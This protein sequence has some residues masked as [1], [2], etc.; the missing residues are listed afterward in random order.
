[1]CARVV[2]WSVL[3]LLL[4]AGAGLVWLWKSR[5][6]QKPAPAAVATANPSGSSVMKS[7]PGT[8]VTNGAGGA[9]PAR[10]NWF[11]YRL[12]NTPQSIGELMRDPQAILLENALIDTRRPVNFSIPPHLRASG[13]PGAYIVQSRGPITAAFR[14]TLA[15]AGAEIVSYIPNNAYLVRVSAAGAGALAGA[16]GVQ[17]VIPYEPYFKLEPALLGLA[18]Q[19]K[20]LPPGT[21]LEVGLFASDATATEQRLA[22]LGAKFLGAPGQSPFGPVV[23]VLAPENWTALAQVPGVQ[24]VEVSHQKI[25]ANDLSR[26]T[27][28]VAADTQTPTNYLNL[29]GKNVLVAVDDTG[30]DATHPDLAGRVLGLNASDLV[31]T[32]GHGTHVAGTI[33]GDGTKSTTVTNAEGSIMPATNG[34]F[35]GMAPKAMLFSVNRNNPDAVLQ[36]LAA[37]TNALIS[38]NS[39]DYGGD[40]D[41]DLAAASYDWATRDA[42]PLVTGAQ[43]VLFVF[44]AGDSG[45]GSDDGTGG[46][47]DTILSP[48]T[49][50]NV[51]TVGALEQL[52]NITNLVTDANS[53]QSAFW[54]PRTDSSTQVAGYSSRG[55]VGVGVEGPFGRFKPDVVAPGTFVISTRSSQW[56]T[57]AYYNPTNVSVT[58][59]T[60]Q[61]VFSNAPA[62]YT[63]SVPPNA[64]GVVI[65]I[66]SNQFSNPFP[67]NL[68]IYVAQNGVPGPGNYDFFTTKDGVSI[69]PDGP[70]NYLQQVQNNGFSFAVYDNLTGPVNYD[71][72]VAILTTNN[73]GNLY[74]VL[75]GMNDA[76]GGYYRYESGT[77][78]A[79]ADVSGVLALIADYFTNQLHEIPSPALLK[80]LLINGARTLSGYSLAFTNGINYQGWGLIN[81]PDSLPLT[82]T[83]LAT[84]P[85]GQ[86]PMPIF[87]VDQS[88][89]NAL[90]TGDRHTYTVTLSTNDFAQ[91]LPLK[92][93]L[94]WSDPPGNPAA[95]IK[96]VNSLELI[97]TNLDTGDVYF[98]NDIPP[99]ASYSQPGDTNAPNFDLV[100]NV[101]SVLLPPP[102]ADRYSVTVLGRQVNV[103]AV[104]E[105]TNNV[106]QDYALVVTVGE[107]EVPTAIAS[108][109]D[110]GVVSNPTADQDVTGVTSTNMPLFNQFAGANTPLLGTNTL[111]LGNNTVWGPNGQVTIGMT[112]QWHFYI[113]TNNAVDQN[114]LTAD[115]TN[116][117]FITFD[118]STLS[119][120]RTG[121]FADSTADATRPEADIDLYVSRDPNL[122]NL[123]PTVISNCLAGVG[124]NRASLGRGGTEFVFYTNSAPGEV[125]YVGVKSED[126]EASEY[127]FMPIFTATPFSQLNQNGDLIVNGLLLPVNIPD[128]D[129]A[130]PGV[131]NVFALA[132]PLI[133]GMTVAKV[134]VTNLNEH[135]NFGDLF[136]ALS[137]GGRSVVLNNHAGYGNTFGTLPRIYDDSLDPVP[138][139]QPSDGPGSLT[140]FRGLSA[141]GPWILTEIDSSLTQTGRVS[142]F[143]LLIQPHRNLKNGII[144]SIPPQGW[145]IDF[146]DVTPGYTNLTFYATNLPPTIGPPPLQMFERLG[147]EPTLTNFDQEADLTNSPPGQPP[148]PNGTDPG[149]LISVG[150]PLDAGRYFVG[151]YNPSTVT[152]NVFLQATLGQG[153]LA[154][155]TFNYS[156]NPATAL[157]DD[158]VSSSSIF[159]PATNPIVSVNVGLIVQTPR[160]SD[161]TFTLISPTGQRILLM[162]NRGGTDT[163][164]VGHL[165]VF[166]NF[167]GPLVSGGLATTNISIGPVPNVGTL[168]INY[169]FF[170][171]PD[172]LAVYYDG[173][174]IFSTTN[175]NPPTGLISG[176]GQF[177]IPY[178]PGLSSNLVVVMNPGGNPGTTNDAWTFTPMVVAEDYNYL[179]FTDDTNLAQ[180]PIKFAIPPFDMSATGTN[181]VFSDFESATNGDYLA[182][183]NIYDPFG[184]WTMVTNRL[185]GTNQVFW[186][187]NLV[188]VAGDPA[189]AQNGSNYLA[190]GLGS[191]RRDVPLTVGRK[192]QIAFG[193]RGPGISAWW[194]GEGNASDS[195]DPEV[196]GNNGRLIGRFQFPAGEVGQAFELADQGGQFDFAGTNNYVQIPQSPSLDVGQG[197]GFTVEGWI[198]PTNVT[199]PQPLVEWLAHV[200]TNSAVTN[201]VILAGPY[202]NRDTGHY[203]YLLGA[204]NWTVSEFWAEQLGGHLAA[205][206]TANEQNW[207]FDNFA[208]YGGTNRNL[209]LG[210]TNTGAAFGWITGDPV[211]YTNWLGGQPN[212]CDGNHSYTF[213]LGQTNNQP[214][215]WT[216]ADNNGFICGSSAT[217]LVYGVAEVPDIQSN[218][219][220]F[221]ICVTNSPVTGQP[222][223]GGSGCLYADIVDTNFVS[224]EI[225]SAPGLLQSNVY[226]HVA[227]TFNAHSGLAELFLNGTNVATTNLFAVQGPFVPK[228]DGDVLLGRDMTRATNND[229][230]GAMDEMSI[231]HRALSDAEIFAIYNVSATA[232]NRLT[233]KFDPSITPALGLAE[234]QVSLGTTTN[235]LLGMNDQWLVNGFTFTAD[236][237]SLPLQI[238]GLE[239]GMLLD[240]FTLTEAPQGNLYYLPEQALDALTGE[241]AYGNWT[242]QI[243]DNRLGAYVTN[244]NQLVSWQ[245][246]FVLASNS[247]VAGALQPQTSAAGTVGPGQI[248]YYTVPVPTWAHDATNILVS[249]TQPVD[250]LFNP[251]NPPTGSNPGDMVLLANSTAGVGSPVLSDNPPSTPPLV[252]GSTYYLGV[253]NNGTKVASVRVEVDFDILALTNGAP[254]TA[255]L[256]TNDTVRYFSCQVGSNAYEATFQLLGITNGNADLVLRKG[257]PLPTLTSSDYGSFNVNNLDENIYVLTNSAPVPLSPGTWYL[258]VFKRDA[259]P[260]GYSVLAKELDTNSPPIMPVVID[261]TNGVPFSGTMGPGADLTNFFRFHV[262]DSAAGGVTNSVQGLRFELYN[263]DGN[264]DLTVQTNALPL[265]PPFWQSSQNPGRGEELILVFTNSALTNLA[266][267]WYLG[268]PNHETRLLHYTIVA[269]VETNAYFPAF[270]GAS[271]MGGGALGAGHAGASNS[272]Y[273]VIYTDDSGGFGTLRD[274]VSQPNRT[275]V[276]D[277]SGIITLQTPLIITNPYLTIAGQTA[278]GGGITVAGNMTAVQSAHDVVIR[279]IRFRPSN[280]CGCCGGAVA[281]GDALQFQNVSNVIADH[282]SAEWSATNL[283]SALNATN[284]TVQWSILADSL[285]N[286]NDLQGAGSLLRY[287]SGGM[288]FNHNLYADNYTGNPRLG[289]NV[290]LDFVNNVIYNWGQFSGLSDD[291]NDLAANP[292]GFTNRLNYSVNYLIAGPDTAAFATTNIAFWGGTTDTWIFQTNNFIDSNT[293]GLLDGANTQWG[294]FTNQYTGFGRPFPLIP[295]PTDEAFL[296]YEKVLDFAGANMSQ[297][298]AV[299]TNIVGK[300]RLQTGQLISAPPLSG[301]VGWWKAEGN[302]NDSIDGNNGV[303]SNITY[304][305]GEV[306][307]AFVFNG[308]NSSVRIPASAC[309][310]VGT[311]NAGFTLE[312]WINPADVNLRPLFEWNS[313]SGSGDVPVGVGLWISGGGPGSLYANLEDTTL[314]FHT[315]SSASGIITPNTFQH[316]ALT[317]DKVTG[318]AVLYRNGVAV[319]TQNLGNA[320]TPQ[321]SFDLYLGER[322]AGSLA[323]V[324]F[325]GLID[326]AAVYNRPLSP[327]EIQAI[328]NAGKTGKQSLL[329]GSSTSLPYLDT[330]QDGIPDFWEMTFTPNLVF[331]PSA[332]HDRDGDGYTDLEEYNNWLAGPHA[333]TVT[334]TPVGVDL[335]QLFGNTGNLSFSVTNAINGSVYLTNVL[336]GVTNSGPFGNH[337]AWFTPANDFGGGT[338]YGFASFDAYVTNNDTLAWFGPVTV[339]VVVSKVP[340]RINSNMPPVITPLVSGVLDPTNYGGS[341]YYV[342]HSTNNASGL[343]FVV[344]NIIGGP[345]DLAVAYNRLPSL[346]DYD[347]LNTNSAE[348]IMSLLVSTNSTPAPLTNGD[349]YVA[350]INVSPSGSQVTYDIIATEY[351]VPLK[352]PVFLFPTNTTVTNILETVPWSVNSVATDPNNP[353]LPLTFALVSGPSNLTVSSSGVISWTPTEAQGPSTNSVAVSVSNGASSVTNTFRIVVEESNLP[354]VFVLTNIPNQTAIVSNLF[355]FADPATDPDLPPN[356]LTY[357]LLAPPAGAAIDTNGVITWMPTAAEAGSNY[358][359]TVVVTD[360]NPWAVNA[361]SLSATNQFYAYVA[362]GAVAGPP[363]TNTVPPGGLQWLVVHVPTNAVAATNTLLFATN[364]P[365]NVWFSA[366]VPPNLTNAVLLMPNATNGVS[367]LT[368]AS[369]PTNIVPG[370]LYFLGVQ[371][372]NSVA[373]TY[374]LQVTFRLAAAPGFAA[375]N[376]VIS[377]IVFTNIGG[378]NGF[379]LTWFAPSN[380]VFRV[381]WTADLAPVNWNTFSNLVTYN[382]NAPAS[383][384]NAQF[385]FFDDGSQ[386][387]GF[388]PTR[389]Y[390]LVLL[391]TNTL[392]L[393]AQ[394]NFTVAVSSVVVVTNTAVDSRSGAVLTY[395]LLGPPAG[396]SISTNGVI[397]WTAGPAGLAARFITVVSD[398]SVPPLTAS[399]QFTVFVAP[400]PAITNVVA[401]ATNVFLSWSAPISDQFQVQWTTNLTP[402][403]VW[404]LFPN[405]ITS[406]NGVFTFTDPTPPQQTKFYQLVLLP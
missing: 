207:I 357:S 45:S 128:G 25:S 294:M 167:F 200:P 193:Y 112:N 326:E 356:P 68:P 232:T 107:G 222:L 300:V 324:Y 279:D 80:A 230:G 189:T 387:G 260:V 211:T 37:E 194:R 296:A 246:S 184:G 137:F 216:L 174:N 332:S 376:L 288:S 66:T 69:P 106:V 315:I 73:V 195:S 304:A 44:A 165:T 328:Y 75:Q 63:V 186:T 133:P 8:G 395:N 24:L 90:A 19:Q 10:T 283:I 180:V 185:L 125:Y 301:M 226:Q 335:M 264:G 43:P 325:N 87:F 282:I 78:M 192:Y 168:L 345:V 401:T 15:G 166:T 277:V 118:S 305:N 311:N 103:N 373:V 84:P 259:G 65:T 142:A 148:Y 164:N 123:D 204:T 130:H 60:G 3:I 188:S 312:A 138:G 120:P 389:Y 322:P 173:V 219:V 147:N 231:Y 109:A 221:W 172:A 266:A 127:A 342:F 160:V 88:T 256:D 152:A 321:T 302:A 177:R 40:F 400:L 257:T 290:S 14:E 52:R 169:D 348:G 393:P 293:N 6:T 196:N 329:S 239:P 191:I 347:Y 307:Q 132:V 405:V 57:N 136:G 143:S 97:V 396:A 317:Y 159:V 156:T 271:G 190:L 383:A 141:I 140:D 404:T 372:P 31:D 47:S 72:S 378:R 361:Q 205:I 113:V 340:I 261:L 13:D 199:R 274:A 355:V 375:T 212:N 352:P 217:N 146:V 71:L 364:L 7:A 135:Q 214:G 287:G 370:G 46:S 381:Q 64:V 139:S 308:T 386:T 203:Y 306:G 122:L 32:D 334:N 225:Y 333:L 380:D 254:Y 48:A 28:G 268:V 27:V 284:L 289:D 224:H 244:A 104:P 111:P 229:Y 161:L 233:G 53:N 198:N 339:R 178:G 35:R 227:L 93:T 83:N 54:L 237:N 388:G 402:P 85:N 82:V 255:V 1:M 126:H 385:N 262:T 76:L 91:F 202:L 323:P 320:W 331:V 336:N 397:T 70:G 181:F 110:N 391:A 269:S 276:F 117:A 30:I 273:H 121:V 286:A 94:A 62:Y 346:S 206:H 58:P 252:P 384:T 149:N 314:T 163:H 89:N 175:L 270:P 327:S 371:N 81:L 9:V 309:L 197:G 18:V 21:A 403:I 337:I 4:L 170:T 96:L 398:D 16:A 151:I 316:V 2:K 23:R 377:N 228:T 223:V 351:G 281:A 392:K 50:K 278:P 267:D 42:L 265:A 295:V 343:L 249:S 366:H 17:A 183:A 243:W 220:Q 129:N 124:D 86:S 365:V 12:S 349:W 344:T 11:A 36:S 213:M 382:T 34:Q 144:V 318:L 275:V 248:I 341:D 299:D 61:V 353:P 145:F 258:G 245:L 313:G 150:P 338:N 182:P 272:V 368:T 5:A 251:S 98:G 176:S 241:S 131:A 215:L 379:L 116:A 49:A 250:L 399:N 330:D 20:P 360:F 26:A 363:P 51:L 362:A 238:T 102:L 114:G 29:T 359:F 406:T 77:S 292:G 134:T 367:V 242:L 187:N 263:Q 153:S 162:E 350:V 115:V 209:W 285:Y 394:T 79:A 155:N 291:T 105:Q 74:S 236:T 369:A 235:V 38:N 280:D 59:Y 303:A 67:P 240:N 22:A 208:N 101:Q 390:R 41:Y 234:A 218:G 99:N 154:N 56:D 374:A 92:V 179:T 33:A 247:P 253:R 354:P 171:Q 100:N 358:L 55:N 39:W 310:N 158:A 319:A 210:L 108:V 297:R 157:L 95:A 201:L 298:D 119:V